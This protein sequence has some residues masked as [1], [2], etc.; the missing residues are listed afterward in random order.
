MEAVL[1][2]CV[3][4][5]AAGQVVPTSLP[6]TAAVPQPTIDTL[7]T[8]SL[9]RSQAPVTHHRGVDHLLPTPLWSF[10]SGAKVRSTSQKVIQPSPTRSR[11]TTNFVP[12]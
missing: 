5:Q 2:S 7:S 6:G 11:M 9:A 1:G 10:R 4:R 12:C 3:I 8:R